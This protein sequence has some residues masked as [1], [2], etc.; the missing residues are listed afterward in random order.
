MFFHFC[1][2]LCIPPE[3]PDPGA[4]KAQKNGGVL[5]SAVFSNKMIN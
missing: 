5:H 2:P 1:K 3:A 4:G